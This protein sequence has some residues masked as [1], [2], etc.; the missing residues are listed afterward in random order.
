MIELNPKCSNKYR[1]NR[2]VFDPTNKLVLSDGVLWDTTCKEEIHKIDV[3]SETPFNGLF[4]PNG[5]EVKCLWTN[6]VKFSL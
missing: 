6:N 5:N 1:K 4:H 3:L 2:A